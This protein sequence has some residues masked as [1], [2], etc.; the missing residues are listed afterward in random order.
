LALPTSAQA[1]GVNTVTPITPREV[2]GLKTHGINLVRMRFEPF[3]SSARWRESTLRLARHGLEVLPVFGVMEGPTA[4][5][6]GF[7]NMAVHRYPNIA[8]IQIGNEPNLHDISPGTY[9]DF[10]RRLEPELVNPPPI[11]LAGLDA[12]DYLA[13]LYRS[14][15]AS[16]FDAVSI[17]PYARTID[18][19]VK[20]VR[21]I[22]HVMDAHGDADKPLYVGEFGWGSTH[23][24]TWNNV[25]QKHQ[26][27]L[28]QHALERLRELRHSLGISR[29]MWWMLRDPPQESPEASACTFCGSSGLLTSSGEP[30]PVW[31]VYR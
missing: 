26:A 24:G 29:I 8:G 2:R 23:D 28:G 21:R 17:H 5:W 4:G 19:I 31:R 11:V 3:G 27:Q 18:G 6:A 13:A 10:L 9:A 25:G 30:K 15:A 7:I 1:L 12:P 14:R 16:L 22:R 20:R